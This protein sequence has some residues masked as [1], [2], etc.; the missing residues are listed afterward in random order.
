MANIAEKP[1]LKAYYKDMFFEFLVHGREEGWKR[2]VIVL[3]P[4]F[5]SSNK[6]DTE[7]KLL[8][9][10]GF[11]VFFPRYKGT[12]QSKGSGKSGFL[13]E[14]IVQDLKE[15]ISELKKGKAKSL[16]DNNLVEFSVGGNIIIFGGS[17]SGAVACG[18]G[19]V[20]K[21]IRKI[22]L[23]S[24][25]W[26]FKKHNESGDE[27]DLEKFIGFVKRTYKNLY[28]IGFENISEEMSKFK[29][30][31]PEFYL[32]R[33]AGN[34]TGVLVLHDPEDKTVSIKHTFDIIKKH[35]WIKLIK[36]SKGHDARNSGLIEERWLDIAEFL[37]E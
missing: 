30:C 31:S 20:D 16:W 15:F 5:P 14:N 13:G 33:L 8:F 2:D 4:G 7:M 27:Q 26:D 17:F 24:P 12:Y 37:K 22:V 11:N 28:R 19:A 29:E 32:N 18:L 9:Q 21:D 10:R 25:V 35:P 6:Y 34:E 1:I 36:H 23:F 3:L